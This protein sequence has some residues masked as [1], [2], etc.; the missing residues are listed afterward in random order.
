M[1]RRY[2]FIF[3]LALALAGACAARA[4]SESPALLSVA[5]GL[6]VLLPGIALSLALFPARDIGLVQRAALAAALSMACVIL[7]ALGVDRVERITA[8]HMTV[9]LGGVAA[10]ALVAA[11]ALAP[12]ARPGGTWHPR[13]LLPVALLLPAVAVAV[14]AV[15]ISRHSAAKEEAAAQFAQL[16][17]RPTSPHRVRLALQGAGGRRSY[18]VRLTARGR[19]IR[20]WPGVAVGGGERWVRST[21][22]PERAGRVRAVVTRGGNLRRAYRSVDA[23]PR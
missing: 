2:G 15:A 12:E 14:L 13:G 7:V 5:G 19:T 22:L 4:F 6:L 3:V 20:S 16:S 23:E 18:L 21:G 9:P 11:A 1:I 17:M 10:L 8:D